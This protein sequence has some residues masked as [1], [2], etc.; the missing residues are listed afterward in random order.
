MN[1]KIVIIEDDAP[2]LEALTQI[3]QDNNYETKTFMSAA[4]F[5]KADAIAE[6]TC[7]LI[8]YRLPDS[9]GVE[10]LKAIREKNKISPAFIM[11]ASLEKDLVLSS[12][13]NGADHFVRKPFMDEEIITRFD[14]ALAKL[15]SYQEL[16]MNKGIKLLHPAYAVLKDGVPLKLSTREFMIFEKLFSSKGILTRDELVSIIQDKKN[17]TIT[18]R[19]L[20]VHVSS[21]RKKVRPLGISIETVWGSG[22]RMHNN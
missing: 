2:I 17:K 7:Y 22:Y 16:N 8:D 1:K 18:Q 10:I 14:N 3:F 9:T 5:L 15:E 21:L 19:N 12:L 13:E 4:D 20:D 6:D 11:T